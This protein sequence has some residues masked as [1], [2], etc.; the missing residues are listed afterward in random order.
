MIRKSGKAVR[1][2]QRQRQTDRQTDR[3]TKR[4]RETHTNTDTDRERGRDRDRQTDRELMMTTAILINT[5][6]KHKLFCFD[7]LCLH[8]VSL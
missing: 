7:F 6:I 8:F 2:R 5:R 4:Q 3:Q 1:E